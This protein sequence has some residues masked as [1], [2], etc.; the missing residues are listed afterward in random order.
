MT[1][2]MSETFRRSKLVKWLRVQVEIVEQLKE[3]GAND[4][5]IKAKAT[6][7]ESLMKEF[8][9]DSNEVM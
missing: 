8:R 6:M 3:H 9:I 5:F 7:I 4:D 2:K 1:V